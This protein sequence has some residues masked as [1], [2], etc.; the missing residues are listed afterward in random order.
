MEKRWQKLDDEVAAA[1]NLTEM[2]YLKRQQGQS[3]SQSQDAAMGH[4][5]A[6]QLLL[7][8][9]PI[10]TLGEQ[11]VQ[12]QRVIKVSKRVFSTGTLQGEKLKETRREDITLLDEQYA[13]GSELARDVLYRRIPP[14]ELALQ[15]NQWEFW[16]GKNPSPSSSPAIVT[17][18]VNV[19][20]KKGLCWYELKYLVQCGRPRQVM[21]LGPHMEERREL[22]LSLSSSSLKGKRKRKDM[23]MIIKK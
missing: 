21:F 15:R 5:L 20:S 1:T 10:S 23:N 3:S 19:V 6:R 17:G 4:C 11:K 7:P 9:S 14:H 12:V 16:V 18:Y 22:K 13:L 8:S 2:M